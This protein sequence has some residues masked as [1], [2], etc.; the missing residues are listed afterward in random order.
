MDLLRLLTALWRQKIIAFLLFATCVG[1]SVGY[2][3]IAPRV[4]ESSASL[5]AAPTETSGQSG[6]FNG[7]VERLLP[8]LAQLAQGE[9][10]RDA[11]SD[12]APDAPPEE[13]RAEALQGTLLLRVN[14]SHRDPQ[15]AADWANEI[16]RVLPSFVSSPEIAT[17]EVTE[18]A[19]IRTT[20]VSPVPSVVLP[21]AVL[22]GLALAVTGAVLLEAARPTR[23]PTARTSR[24]DPPGR[25]SRD[26]RPVREDRGTWRLGSDPEDGADHGR[27]DEG[28][29]GR[30][31]VRG[32]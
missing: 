30:P 23:D 18:R 1:A 28:N 29:G 14:V 7:L 20:P 22:L 21:L 11:A 19:R 25:G 17:L 12:R 10:V 6:A 2:L 32:A 13:V 4:Y 15:A 5:A 24:R 9:E 8:T 3:Q 26:V 31:R 27:E 16:A